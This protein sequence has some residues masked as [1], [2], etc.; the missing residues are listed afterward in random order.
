[1]RKDSIEM[2]L[3]FITCALETTWP[4]LQPEM[5]LCLC[6]TFRSYAYVITVSTEH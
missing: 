4:S 6:K 5:Q 2:G 3:G 1:M